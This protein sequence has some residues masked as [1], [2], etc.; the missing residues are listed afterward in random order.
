VADV[1]DPRIVA[2]G[3]TYKKNCEDMRESPAIEIVHLLKKDGYNV[4]H[5]D[6]MVPKMG[7]SSL[8]EAVKGADLVAV[9]VCHGDIKRDLTNDSKAIEQ[10]MRHHRVCFFDE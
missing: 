3:A 8:T 2:L 4:V 1:P 9:L 7:F 5:Y 10:A 6:P